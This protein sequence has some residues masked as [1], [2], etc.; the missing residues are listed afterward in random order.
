MGIL[1]NIK[2][3]FLLPIHMNEF[4]IQLNL[5]EDKWK[6]NIKSDMDAVKANTNRLVELF[7]DMNKEMINI[8]SK[9]NDIL[10]RVK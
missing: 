10:K 9:L 4:L 8:N 2:N 6:F 1:R 3:F 7:L 5:F